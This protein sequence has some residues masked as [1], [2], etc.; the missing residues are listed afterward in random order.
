M[1]GKSFNIIIIIAL[2]STSCNL[3]KRVNTDLSGNVYIHN[4]ILIHPQIIEDS[5][6]PITAFKIERDY[7]DSMLI[8]YKIGRETSLRAI[9]L[10]NKDRSYISAGKINF[11]PNGKNKGMCVFGFNDSIST[12]S[13]NN[14]NFI[15]TLSYKDKITPDSVL[16]YPYYDE[17][18]FSL[19]PKKV[20]D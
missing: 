20:T 2:L 15:Y 9:M 16:L 6:F 5:I 11:S 3:G 19:F 1:G 13:Y 14:T 17:F 7:K 18:G 10:S 4:S 8:S 12:L